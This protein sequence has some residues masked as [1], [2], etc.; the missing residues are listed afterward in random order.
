MSDCLLATT[1]ISCSGLRVIGGI[2]LA[3]RGCL[4]NEQNNPELHGGELRAT[5]HEAGDVFEFGGH[6]LPIQ[7][8][9]GPATTPSRMA[10]GRPIQHHVISAGQA[11]PLRGTS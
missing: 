6:K 7:G 9:S 2:L 8:T 11:I 4:L 5:E 10:E 1:E 3:S